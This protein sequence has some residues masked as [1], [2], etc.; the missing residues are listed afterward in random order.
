VIL[1]IS[2]L[3]CGG[4]ERVAS[5]MADYWARRGRPVTLVTL[6]TSD[7]DFYAVHEDV[8]RVDLGLTRERQGPLAVWGALRRLRRYLRGAPAPVVISY[9]TRVN[10][11]TLIAARGLGKR[12]VVT[13]H[14]HPVAYDLGR[15]VNRLRDRLYP[16]ADALTVL[17]QDVDAS[18]ARPMMPE[19]RTA[20]MPNFVHLPEGDG[21][22]GFA[23]EIPSRYVVAAGRLVPQKGF[24]LLLEAFAEV[25]REHPDVLLLILGEGAERAALERQRDRL[26][27]GDAVWMPGAVE[28][29]RPLFCG[30]DLFV[31]SSRFEG[32]GNV[33]IEAMSCGT[34]PVSFACPSGPSEIIRDGVDGLLVPPEDVGRLAEAMGSL[35]ADEARREAM[36]SAARERAGAF[37]VDSVMPRWDALVERVLVQHVS[38]G[39][40]SR[41][42]A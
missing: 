30:A 21:K 40:P 38:P 1:V 33:L 27:M 16:G 32:F 3:V 25:R 7:L 39:R 9:M 29:I 13:E 35:L 42:S 11:L 2:S 18:W 8:Q 34:P 20:V 23:L 37:T 17:T 5:G 41:T 12:V 22:P 19:G 14:N 4:A 24:D 15:V 36:G 31:F 28:G 10:L 26:G 6:Y